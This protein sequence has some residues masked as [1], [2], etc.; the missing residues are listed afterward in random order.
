MLN[1]VCPATNSVATW[2]L[3]LG[4]SQGSNCC[5]LAVT[6]RI[7]NTKPK[8]CWSHLSKKS[9]HGQWRAFMCKQPRFLYLEPC[10]KED[11]PSGIWTDSPCH[12]PVIKQRSKQKLH[13]IHW[14]S[15]E[16]PS[17][18]MATW[19]LNFFH[20]CFQ[21]RKPVDAS[22]ACS[23]ETFPVVVRI[24]RGASGFAGP[25][26]QWRHGYWNWFETKKSSRWKNHK[27]TVDSPK[28]VDIFRLYIEYFK[29]HQKPII[30]QIWSKK[31]NLRLRKSRLKKSSVSSIGGKVSATFTGP[32]LPRCRASARSK[33]SLGFQGF[34]WF[35]CGLTKKKV[36]LTGPSN[37]GN[38]SFSNLKAPSFDGFEVWQDILI[39]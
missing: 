36:S 11:N 20:I 35:T 18:F 12:H 23:G 29:N 13:E 10:I 27:I 31:K 38:K 15:M 6:T 1:W 8:Q 5:N 9:G 17:F 2:V 22:H 16:F 28:Y 37:L 19:A 21:L 4:W 30:F 25:E 3:V 32:W 7:L 39:A 24:P 34:T 14:T 26:K 33:A